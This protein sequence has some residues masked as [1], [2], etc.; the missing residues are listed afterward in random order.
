MIDYGD[1][2]II[3]GVSDLGKSR[4]QKKRESTALQQMGENLAA[5]APSTLREFDLP[6]ELEKAVSDLRGIKKHEARRR[7]LQYIGRLMREIDDDA[8]QAICARL[9][10]MSLKKQRANDEFHHLEEIRT[11]L[12]EERESESAVAELRQAFPTLQEKRLRHLIATAQAE[13]AASKPPKAYRELFRF[14]RSLE[15]LGEQK[16]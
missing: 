12:L 10:E 9:D 6:P 3:H 13:R 5:L 2:E 16:K 14:L 8:A 15:E 11:R 1:T 4:S 7:Q